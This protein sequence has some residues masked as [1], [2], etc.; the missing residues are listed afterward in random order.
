[1]KQNLIKSVAL[2]V[3]VMVFCGC[4]KAP[5]HNGGLLYDKW[6][7]EA[8]LAEPTTDHPLWATRPDTE[9]N[10]RTGK[11]TWRCKECHGWD[12]KGVDG[13]YGSGSHRTGF[14]GVFGVDGTALR[15][16]S[17]QNVFDLIKTDHSYG[18]VLSDEDISDLTEFV[19]AGQ[20]DTANIIDDEGAFIGD[21]AAGQATYNRKCDHCH[22][23]DGLKAPVDDPD[24]D[25][26]P[27]AV[28]NANPWEMQHKLSF[29]QPATRMSALY[30]NLSVL[31]LGDLGAFLQTLPTELPAE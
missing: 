14:A 19:M 6:W 1:M 15:T 21:A 23:K 9:S 12:Y 16:K 27:G 18:T 28:A 30:N 10:T 24:Y 17:S 29:G 25:A 8:D 7:A 4:P 3:M 13:A 20:I 2:L 26:F 11:D 31:E 22:G 5:V